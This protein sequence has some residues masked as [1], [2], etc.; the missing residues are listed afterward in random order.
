MVLRDNRQV[1]ADSDRG[2]K[3][4]VLWT[5]QEIMGTG[6]PELALEEIDFL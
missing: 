4:M 3:P 5:R 6:P 2:G 1:L